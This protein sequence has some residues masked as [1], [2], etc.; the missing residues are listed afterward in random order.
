MFVSCGS[1]EGD[2]LAA[3]LCTSKL[4]HVATICIKNIMSVRI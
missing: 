3:R 1:F 4:D 2:V